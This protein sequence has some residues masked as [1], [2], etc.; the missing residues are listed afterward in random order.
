MWTVRIYVQQ[1]NADRKP[2]GR[3]YVYIMECSPKNG[4]PH[5]RGDFGEHD[6]TYHQT[7][8]AAVGAALERMNQSCEV[9]IY[10]EDGFV[11]SMFHNRLAE[12]AG[13]D[14]MTSRGER[15]ANQR[16]WEAVW[17]LTRGQLVHMI[18]G[19][20]EYSEI[21]IQKMQG[22]KEQCMKYLETLT[23]QKK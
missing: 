4:K 17:K 1:D 9:Y 7:S 3:N 15:I 8:L 2:A 22:G 16:E 14:W 20:H 23:V 12:W 11:C 21:L 19:K 10:L 18:P 13:N 5:R 6:G